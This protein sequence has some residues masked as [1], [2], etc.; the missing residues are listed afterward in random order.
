MVIRKE[1]QYMEQVKVR[2]NKP[3][4]SYKGIS[5]NLRSS[6]FLTSMYQGFQ[7]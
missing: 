6:S 5:W 1:T 2:K 4:Y 3:K 7:G